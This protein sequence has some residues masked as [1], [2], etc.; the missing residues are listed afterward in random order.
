MLFLSESDFTLTF[1]L[2]MRSPCKPASPPLCTSLIDKCVVI[3]KVDD[4]LYLGGKASL[5]LRLL[6]RSLRSRALI[7]GGDGDS[8]REV[9]KCR[10]SDRLNEDESLK[11][12]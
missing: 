9:L 10:L 8:Y 1:F 4:S 2:V 6:S 7:G 11:E 5:L 12:D 3:F